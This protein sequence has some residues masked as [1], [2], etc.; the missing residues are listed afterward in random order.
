MSR[1]PWWFGVVL[2]PV[3]PLLSLLSGIG[4]RTFI[5]VST[6]AGDPNVGV[7]IASFLLTVVSFWGDTD[8]TGRTPV[9]ACR[10]TSAQTRPNVVASHR[11]G[12]GRS[13]SS[14][15]SRIFD[16]VR[17]VS[18]SA[19]VLPV[20]TSRTRLKHRRFRRAV[21]EDPQRQYNTN[22]TSGCHSV[23]VT[24]YSGGNATTGR[25]IIRTA[26]RSVSYELPRLVNHNF[27]N[28]LHPQSI[29]VPLFP[30]YPYHRNPPPAR[31]RQY[32]QFRLPRNGR[33]CHDHV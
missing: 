18:P 27:S 21:A 31:R 11:L 30:L 2:F 15:R 24:D 32:P 13:R 23:D 25:G 5:A 20:P 29:C 6:S 33:W 19:F 9:P 4:S 3:V 26:P 17:S 12:V 28:G 8:R 1:F 22:S 10:Y 14:R 16:V 7:G